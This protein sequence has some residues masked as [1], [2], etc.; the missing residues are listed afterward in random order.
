M[1]RVAMLEAM[2]AAAKRRV[3]GVLSKKRRRHYGHAAMLVACCLE[4]GPVIGRQE[5]MA[6]WVAELRQR[7]SRFHAFQR[8]VDHALA[9]VSS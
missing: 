2:Q 1:D 4:L 3:D 5:V 7:Y 9:E 6:K 8:E